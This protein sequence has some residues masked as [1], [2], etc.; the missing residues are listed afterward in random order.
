M[1]DLKF[2]GLTE[3]EAK[4][5]TNSP[6]MRMAVEQIIKKNGSQMASKMRRNMSAQYTGHYEG[7]RFVK[8]TG[9]TKRSV[10]ETY[11]NSGMKVAV[12]PH[13]NYAPYLEYGT[14]FM[15]PRPTIRP[16]FINQLAIFNKDMKRLVQ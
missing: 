13:T 4:L 7:K 12:G 3:L 11:S 2:N 5:K 8:P 10:T 15:I 1:L 6:Q 9:A 14:R 16:A